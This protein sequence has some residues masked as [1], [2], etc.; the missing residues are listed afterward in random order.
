M[1]KP[2]QWSLNTDW[3]NSLL[4]SMCAFS[5]SKRWYKSKNPWGIILK[6]LCAHLMHI[7][8]WQL[9]IFWNERTTRR[10]FL[11]RW[12]TTENY[13]F[14]SPLVIVSIKAWFAPNI[15][16]PGIGMFGCAGG[17]RKALTWSIRRWQ[18]RWIQLRPLGTGRSH[19]QQILSHSCLVWSVASSW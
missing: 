3:S 4:H 13:A 6:P 11:I 8:T 10:L 19:L 7:S 9:S 2:R 17:G 1:P 16:K 18:G 5:G 12:E 15:R 14:I